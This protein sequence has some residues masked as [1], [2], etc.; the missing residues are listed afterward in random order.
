M[1]VDYLEFNIRGVRQIE[2][3][4]RDLPDEA[5]QELDEAKREV[6]EGLADIVRAA[7]VADTRQSAA[8]ARTVRA[9]L[10]GDRPQVIAGPEKRL[11]GSEFGAHR[12][13][14]WYG[15]YR[16]RDSVG[17]TYRA[18]RGAASYWFFQAQEDAQPWVDQQWRAAEDAIIR[19]WG[20]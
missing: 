1:P 19:R 14:G 8:A 12:R 18:H 3:A 7:G 20:A 5:Q 6:A 15:R 13:F 4:L 11:F 2:R 10:G 17:R 9:E 16:Y